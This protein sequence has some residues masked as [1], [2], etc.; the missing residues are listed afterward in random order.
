M[1]LISNKVD[2]ASEKQIL[3]K[4]VEEKTK[5]VAS[6]LTK[7]GFCHGDSLYFITYD[8]VDLE[9][10]QFA[11]WTLGGS[12]RGG[13]QKGVPGE[14]LTLKQFRLK[15]KFDFAQRKLLGR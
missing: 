6:A 14:Q 7:R 15:I 9:I 8:F 1:P 2:T 12:T 10:L 4:D 11:V 5:S 13:F 3:F